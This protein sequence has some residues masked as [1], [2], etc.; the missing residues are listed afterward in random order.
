M[1]LLDYLFGEKEL[2]FNIS[3]TGDWDFNEITVDVSMN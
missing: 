1:E 2:D 3:S